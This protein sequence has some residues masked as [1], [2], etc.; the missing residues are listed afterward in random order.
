MRRHLLTWR[1]TGAILGLVLVGGLCSAWLLGRQVEAD[2][3]DD[4]RQQL[5]L[6]ARLLAGWA[7]QDA[8]Q[9]DQAR[10]QALT[11]G[12]G[13][14][15]TLI[16]ADGQVLADSQ[17]D[18]QGVDNH[19]QRPEVLAARAAG[20]MQPA[21]ASRRSSTVGGV[22]H[23]CAVLVPDGRVVRAAMADEPLQQRIAR[24]HQAVSMATALASV[25]VIII[26]AVLA[27][28][29]TRP[30]REL[31]ACAQAMAAGQLGLWPELRRNDEIG[32]LAAAFADMARELSRRI[33]QLSTERSK[34]ASILGS[35]VQGVIAVDAERRVLHHN[36]AALLLL[37]SPEGMAVRGLSAESLRSATDG[38]TG[39]GRPLWEMVRHVDL[40]A[41]LEGVL[42]TGVPQQRE[43]RVPLLTGVRILEAHADMIRDPSGG[44]VGAVAV[45]HDLSEL[46]RLE[47]VRRD[48]VANVSH[49][50]K[51]PLA[52]IIG[53]VETILDDPAMPEATR[54]S[55]LERLHRQGERLGQLVTDLLTLSRIESPDTAVERVSLNLAAI[56]RR[57]VTQLQTVAQ[58]RR[59]TLS[60]E[61]PERD[62]LVD[63][64]EEFLR[65]AIDN[66]VD[67]AIK[68]TPEGGTVR[69][70]LR[71]QADHALIEVI[72]TGIG[73][74]GADQERI[75]ERFYRVDKARSRH[76]GGT[77][78]GLAIVKHV[79]L[80]HGGA[81]AVRSAPG[82]G[83]TFTL[84]LPL[85]RMSAEG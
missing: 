3:Q 41:L 80:S 75:F 74:T 2:G 24:S 33:G 78:L 66:L 50:L 72:D 53:L 45:L 54:R 64:D 27:R 1:I 30:L 76:L 84:T 55:F 7:Q 11:A 81:V 9:P 43:L 69:A 23:Y 6:H 85:R 40:I 35:M 29:L 31:T 42:A 56:L 60:G 12:H 47:A 10:L 17:A 52:A 51:T 39:A 16:A 32:I 13:L 44:I 15:L 65:Q 21:Y 5:N 19:N 8:T 83:S 49:E 22:L 20:P 59:I 58:A 25:L 73:I 48:F 14:R 71:V 34:L 63:G 26:G 4:I 70:V 79:A 77:G 28:R 68:Y 57:S 61:I 36:A 62:V 18:L 67:N 46:R 82:E 37:G 38:G